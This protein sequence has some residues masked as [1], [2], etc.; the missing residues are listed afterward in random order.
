MPC[1]DERF[2][3][4]RNAAEIESLTVRNNKLMRVICSID[5]TLKL[6]AAQLEACGSETKAV[7]LEHRARDVKRKSL[8]RR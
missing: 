1:Y 7:V 8:N 3:P 6:T 4:S 2:S 5:K